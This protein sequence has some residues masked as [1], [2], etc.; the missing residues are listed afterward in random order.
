MFL[1][2]F[3][4]KHVQQLQS[5]SNFSSNGWLCLLFGEMD[6]LSERNVY[7]QNLFLAKFLQVSFLNVLARF[8]QQS[9]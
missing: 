3:D 6:K 7:T 4:H 1:N 8:L 9:C 5:S 2:M